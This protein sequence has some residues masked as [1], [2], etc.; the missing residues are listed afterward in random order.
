MKRT[1]ALAAILA[2]SCIGCTNDT[3][4]TRPG[5]PAPNTNQRSGNGTGTGTGS[6][7]KTNNRDTGGPVTPPPSNPGAPSR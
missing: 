5:G 6:P 4:T 3:N 1:I 2:L 7:D